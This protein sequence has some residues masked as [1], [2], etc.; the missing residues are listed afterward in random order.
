MLYV[1]TLI[2][3]S[4]INDVCYSFFP[5]VHTLLFHLIIHLEVGL[6]FVMATHIPLVDF[7]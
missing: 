1:Y 2:Y 7:S 5:N 3:I 6:F 4:Y